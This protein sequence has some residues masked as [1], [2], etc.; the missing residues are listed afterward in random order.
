[1]RRIYRFCS[2]CALTFLSLN[3][4]SQDQVK[5]WYDSTSVHT[6]IRQASNYSED[7]DGIG[8]A[9][10]RNMNQ[11]STLETLLEDID[12]VLT[13][14]GIPHRFYVKD[15]EKEGWVICYLLKGDFNGPFS[16]VSGYN[17]LPEIVRDYKAIYSTKIGSK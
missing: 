9:V 15:I 6:S 4:V 12:Y 2:F 16:G 5:N 1:M 8:I 3:C 11:S 7:F 17:I 10:L 13:E 14:M